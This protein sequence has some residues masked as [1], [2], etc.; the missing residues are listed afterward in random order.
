MLFQAP[1]GNN[2]ITP[3]ST[4]SVSGPVELEGTPV[5]ESSEIEIPTTNKAS[6]KRWKRRR[7]VD[8]KDNSTGPVLEGYRL[9][10]ITAGNF[11]PTNG[12]IIRTVSV[13]KEQRDNYRLKRQIL[14]E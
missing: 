12:R 11:T 7:T 14:L 2:E 6:K 4:L 8:D 1:V 5:L 13:D 9:T 10:F 3:A